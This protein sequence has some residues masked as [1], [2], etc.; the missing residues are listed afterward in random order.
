M[1]GG[2]KWVQNYKCPNS[3]V[4]NIYLVN[5]EYYVRLVRCRCGPRLADVDDC[6]KIKNGIRIIL[7]KL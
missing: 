3:N 5:D 6:I 7:I 1:H 2:N 4:I